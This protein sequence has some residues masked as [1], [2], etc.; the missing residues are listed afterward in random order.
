MAEKS[1]DAELLAWAAAIINREQGNQT[2]GTV[3]VHLQAG[4][5]VRAAV[6]R[7]ETPVNGALN[8]R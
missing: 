1:T 3:T 5:I 6:E 2:Y 8:N 7:I 4:R